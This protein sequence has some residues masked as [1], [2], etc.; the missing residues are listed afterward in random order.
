ME[1]QIFWLYSLA[2]VSLAW[3]VFGM[4]IALSVLAANAVLA[5]IFWYAPVYM[6][7]ESGL[8]DVLLIG[9]PLYWGVAF[10]LFRFVELLP[11]PAPPVALRVGAGCLAALAFV[12]LAN[13]G[14]IGHNARLLYAA[15]IAPVQER[16]RL[17]EEEFARAAYGQVCL[18]SNATL[19]RLAMGADDRA[20]VAVLLDA[21]GR[22]YSASATM[23]E[24]VKPVLDAGDVHAFELLLESGLKPG[25]LVSGSPYRGSV[26]AYAAGVA[27]NRELVR[28][29]VR[30]YPEEAKTLP[31]LGVLQGDLKSANNNAMLRLLR[32]LKVLPPE[33]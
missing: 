31:F 24:V 5:C 26:L 19:M 29:L 14:F 3:G 27:Q 21:F 2:S 9:Y 32:E 17:L 28:V 8:A 1:P 12:L 6:P 13:W 18:D 15:Y 10:F 11:L 25:S 4:R 33:D 7:E 30:R 23:E 16:P 20:V 22:C